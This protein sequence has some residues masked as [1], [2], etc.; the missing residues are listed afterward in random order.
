M[1][2]IVLLV[3]IIW[4]ALTATAATRQLGSHLNAFEPAV[5]SELSIPTDVII[6]SCMLAAGNSV[7]LCDRELVTFRLKSTGELMLTLNCKGP[8]MKEKS[9]ETRA[10]YEKQPS[11]YIVLDK[12]YLKGNDIEHRFE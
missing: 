11:G 2:R 12:L 9:K 10:V 7:V 6:G 5:K 4:V 1:R 8:Q 3:A